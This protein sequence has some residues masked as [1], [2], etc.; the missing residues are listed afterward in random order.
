MTEYK[1]E[2]VEVNDNVL[3]DNFKSFKVKYCDDCGYA[4]EMDGSTVVYHTDF[5]SVGLDRETC[6]NCL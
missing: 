6:N 1:N 4:Y 2:I 3:S 5:P